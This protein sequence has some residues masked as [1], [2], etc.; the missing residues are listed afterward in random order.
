VLAL[1][2]MLASFAGVAHAVEFDEKVKAPMVKEPATL[3]T[4]A[5]SYV[6]KFN[7]QRATSP[8]E[9]VRSR[10][11]AAERFDLSWQIQQAIDVGNP[12]GD[13]TAVGI[14]ARKD[15]SYH[16]DYNENPQWQRPEA[17]FMA[18]LSNVDWQGLTAQLV[19]RGFRESDVV[20]LNDYM[21]AHDLVKDSSRDSLPITLSFSK[22]VKK[23]DKIK[24]P[25]DDATVLS[26]IYQREKLNAEKGRVWAE[27]LL[28]SLDAQSTRILLAYIDEFQSTGVW[29]PSD[30]RAGIDE[31]LRTMRLPN[32]DQLATA[33]VTGGAP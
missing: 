30:R 21:S 4:Q 27:G 2:L 16:I 7:A 9:V 32:F 28:D 19:S 29:A 25:V 31:L 6:A 14:E 3:R 11:L 15:G 5:Q 17:P 18:L 33:E 12:L 23:Y 13:L 20:K 10:A 26:Y 24:R 1:M 8:Q 22:I